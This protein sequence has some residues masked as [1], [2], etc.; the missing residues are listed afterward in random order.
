VVLALTR[1]RRVVVQS[2]EPIDALARSVWSFLPGTV[3]R[4]A[5]VATWAFDNDNHFDLV[6][7]PKLAGVALDAS[8]L[9]LGFE[10]ATL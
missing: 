5:T 9:I 4:R 7:M 1:G 3:R 6:A 2:S 10:H 8:D